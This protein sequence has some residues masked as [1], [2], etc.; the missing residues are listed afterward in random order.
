MPKLV[1]KVAIIT[2]SG[3]G[4]GRLE[5]IANAAAFVASSEADFLRSHPQ[6][7]RW[8]CGSRTHVQSHTVDMLGGSGR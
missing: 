5:E 6:R 3:R 7:G 4:I 2:G 1:N 8:F